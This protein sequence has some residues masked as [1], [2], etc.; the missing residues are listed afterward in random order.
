MFFWSNPYKMEVMIT[1]LIKSYGVNKPL[2]QNTFILRRHRVAKLADISI[3]ASIP[4]KTTFKE[5][6][7]F[8]RIRNYILKYNVHPYFLIEKKLLISSEK[9]LTSAELKEYVMWFINLLDI[10]KVRYN[11][12]K[13]YHCRICVTDFMERGPV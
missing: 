9:K 4:V 10:F 2:F 5:S 1:S 13:F 6:K 7:K 11:C 12:V 3:I 8:K